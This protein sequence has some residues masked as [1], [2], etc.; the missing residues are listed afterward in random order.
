MCASALLGALIQSDLPSKVPNH[1]RL[2]NSVSRMFVLVWVQCGSGG[3]GK[4]KAYM[5]NVSNQLKNAKNHQTS[6]FGKEVKPVRNDNELL[7][8]NVF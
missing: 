2:V 1:L 6:V 7:F 5:A 4:V 8:T 3:F